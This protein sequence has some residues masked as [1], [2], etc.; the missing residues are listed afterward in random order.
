MR[1]FEV[2][3]LNNLLRETARCPTILVFPRSANVTLDKICGTRYQMFPEIVSVWELNQ[4]FSVVGSHASMSILLWKTWSITTKHRLEIL[5]LA[6]HNFINLSS[7]HF[8]QRKVCSCDV[9]LYPVIKFVSQFAVNE[10][11]RFSNLKLTGGRK[12]RLHTK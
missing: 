10:F 11:L 3:L 2:F 7:F 9:F 4:F 5:H 12:G 6:M 1:L 8:V